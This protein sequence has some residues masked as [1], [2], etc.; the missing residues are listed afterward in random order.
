MA[1]PLK[2][3]ECFLDL[4]PVQL[5]RTNYFLWKPLFIRTLKAYDLDL[6][7]IMEGVE[8]CPPQFATNEER[9]ENP[10][11]TDWIMKDQTCMAVI[12]TTLSK[13][14][15][16][17]TL[18]CTSSRALW[19]NLEI[20]FTTAAKS[21]CLRLKARMQSLKKGWMQSMEKYLNL[22]EE[23]ANELAA[24]GYPLEDCDYVGHVLR[25]LPSHYDD[26]VAWMRAGGN[27]AVTREELHGLLLQ[28]SRRRIQLDF[29]VQPL[30]IVCIT[31]II[32][33]IRQ[34]NCP[35]RLLDYVIVTSLQVKQPLLTKAACINCPLAFKVNACL[36][37]QCG[38]VDSGLKC[39][40]CPLAF[41]VNA[42]LMHECGLA[43]WKRSLTSAAALPLLPVTK[44]IMKL[45][46]PSLAF[47]VSSRQ[48][49]NW[50]ASVN[51]CS[52]EGI[53]CGQDDGHQRVVG[54]W[55]PG[56][57][58]TGIL[59]SDSLSSLSNLQVLDLSS[60]NF[61]GNIPDQISN[62]TNLE[63]LN[64]SHNHLS[65]RVPVWHT[66]IFRALYVPSGG[67]FRN[68]IFSSFE[69]IPRLRGPPTTHLS[70]PHLE[71]PAPERS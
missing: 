27:I 39:I 1:E 23:I 45:S 51:C 28:E 64:L 49:L 14:V 60:N 17:Y 32:A 7:N 68:F 63:K 56:R 8:Q 52:W 59:P 47:K 12:T 67:Q 13:S 36:M 66:M 10:A 21:H 5:T 33:L 40:N 20:R 26:F 4:V 16:P 61:S 53:S 9:D 15:L 22:A 19:L 69:G 42:Y 65:G 48:P 44:G 50:S 30:L 3:I 46:C 62:L 25:G 54:P 38:L 58:L 41:K 70:C 2:E 18:G 55:L 43:K 57:G 11:Y 71:L 37:R 35:H 31:V 6:F 24:G 29:I 34:P